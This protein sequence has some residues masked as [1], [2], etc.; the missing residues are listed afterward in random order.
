MKNFV[1]IFLLLFLPFTGGSYSWQSF[2]PDTIYANNICFGVGSWKGVI[3]SPNGMYLWEPD[4]EEW[5]FYTYGLPVTGAAN[6]DESR[7]LVT[8][9]DGTYSD[10]IYTFHLETHQFEVVEWL[11]KP[12]F[13]KYYDYD[14]RYYVGLE[15]NG[16]YVSSNGMDWNSVGY[17]DTIS[18]PSMDFFGEHIIA[19]TGTFGLPFIYFSDDAGYSWNISNNGHSSRNVKFNNSGVAYSILPGWSNS[20]GIYYSDDYGYSWAPVYW[21]FLIN[22]FGIDAMGNIFLGWDNGVGIGMLYYPNPYPYPDLLLLNEGLP[23]LN[24]NEIT[25]NP[26]MSAIAIFCC[27]DA[28]VYVS[29]D[30]MVGENENFMDTEKITIFP[31]PVSDEMLIQL[32]LNKPINSIFKI[33]VYDNQGV[34]VDEIKFENNTSQN[35]EIKWNAGDLHAGVYYLL[36]RNKNETVT[37]KFIVL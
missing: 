16:L 6:L 28:G 37:E 30:Y 20:S 19:A 13:L 27:T 31:N 4:I 26:A 32:T 3:C 2:C 18:C 36:V 15:E 14:Q 34:K 21:Q 25:V 8:M 10:G 1:K 17:F 5:S 9:G 35:L 22:A 29:Y 12:V 11:Y 24:I 33:E 23:N 7:I